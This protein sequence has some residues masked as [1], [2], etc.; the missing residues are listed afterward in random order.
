MADSDVS[1]KGVVLEE[2]S[3]VQ[4]PNDPV[5]SLRPCAANVE[6]K[7]VP[8][9][10]A[11]VQDP[12]GVLNGSIANPASRQCLDVFACDKSVG[13]PAWM[14]PCSDDTGANCGSRNQLWTRLYPGHGDGF[15]LQTRMQS[16]LCLEA[17]LLPD[18]G[19]PNAYNVTMQA[20]SKP[21]G[22]PV[23]PLSQST[24]SEPTQLWQEVGQTGQLQAVGQTGPGG[25]AVCLSAVP[26]GSLPQASVVAVGVRLGGTAASN[27]TNAACA[28]Y[29]S[30][31]Y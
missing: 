23:E 24:G 14:W 27:A 31:W 8:G 5:L 9:D 20:C 6:G 2:A 1:V 4:T 22:H 17:K 10:L 21:A 12:G 7:T 15:Q 29:A 11:W 3:W 18:S 25:K 28:A 16:G 19:I 13:T 26:P 30:S